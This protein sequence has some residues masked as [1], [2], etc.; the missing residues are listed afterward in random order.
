MQDISK[1]GMS[2]HMCKIHL[3]PSLPPSLLPALTTMGFPPSPAWIKAIDRARRDQAVTS[4]RAAAPRAIDPTVVVNIPV[5]FRIRA[6]T[7]KAVMEMET[8]INTAKDWKATF[9]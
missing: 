8:Q 1:Q 6:R 2:K 7:G 9:S 3:P 5:S 4:S